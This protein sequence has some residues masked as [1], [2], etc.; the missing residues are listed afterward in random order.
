MAASIE[1]YVEALRSLAERDR[2]AAHAATGAHR[3]RARA[4]R[5]RLD[6]LPLS[7][8]R[9]LPG[10]PLAAGH[11]TGRDAITL[12]PRR[13][14]L[15][16]MGSATTRPGRA[17]SSAAPPTSTP[18]LFGISPREALGMELQQR[19]LLETAWKTLRTQA[20]I[21]PHALKRPRTGVFVGVTAVS[22]GAGQGPGR[23][24]PRATC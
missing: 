6:G 10:R 8:R 16:H 9:R 17:A 18:D 2:T 3:R 20:G 1:D 24:R 15:E 21:D 12:A 14:R 13:P 22:Y 5:H 23:K 7:R 19:L 11:Q 4:H